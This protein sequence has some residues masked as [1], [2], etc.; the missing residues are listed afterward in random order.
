MST[1]DPRKS[2]RELALVGLAAVV[3]VVAV[4]QLLYRWFPP[5]ARLL[6]A[7]EGVEA[8][9]ASNP[10]TVVLGSSHARSFKAVQELV[11]KR[12][13]GAHDMVIVPEEGGLFH[14]YNWITQHRLKPLLLERTPEGDYKRDRLQNFLLITTVYDTCPVDGPGPVGLPAQAW[15]FADFLADVGRSGVTDFNRNYLRARWNELWSGSALV[16]DRGVARIVGKLR[17]L[18]SGE[19]RAH[20]MEDKYRQ[21]LVDYAKSCFDPKQ[22]AAF[23]EILQITTARG[24]DTTIVIF[25]LDPILITEQ[26]RI[27]TLKRFSALVRS[28]QRRYPIRVVNLTERTPLGHE[29][30]MADLDHVTPAGNRKFAAWALDH[31]LAFLV[32]GKSEVARP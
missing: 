16:Q 3:T 29:D 22:L 4:D 6:Q 32:H 23:E 30:F 11:A 12:T 1:S 28:Y 19:E 14:A 17:W 15:T 24:L 26:A 10:R 25:P 31:D 18:L 13:E 9:A 2:W 8:L 5:D 27:A 7:H 21:N 20:A